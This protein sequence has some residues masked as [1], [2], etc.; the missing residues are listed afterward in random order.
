[1]QSAMHVEI[2]LAPMVGNQKNLS[3][4][5]TSKFVWLS[6]FKLYSCRNACVWASCLSRCDYNLERFDPSRNQSSY[7]T[8]ARE[9][10]NRLRVG[11]SV[12]R[13]HKAVNGWPCKGVI[14]R[15]FASHWYS[16]TSSSMAFSG[17]GW[18]LAGRGT[19][20]SLQMEV[21]LEPC[22]VHHSHS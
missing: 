18:D 10:I 2:E 7:A 9:Q 3:A 21:L 20:Q 15:L 14:P 1:M 6:G 16:V 8:H 5:G 22:D 12:H 4:E 13:G 11:C 17:G 19:L